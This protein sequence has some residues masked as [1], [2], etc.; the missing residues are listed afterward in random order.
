MLIFIEDDTPV[1]NIRTV[2]VE[3]CAMLPPVFD[4]EPLLVPFATVPSAIAFG[5]V[6]VGA[7]TAMFTPVVV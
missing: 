1:P 7:T 4:A 6:P 3:P 5:L 2:I